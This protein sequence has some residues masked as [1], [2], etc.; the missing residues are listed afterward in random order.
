MI[1]PVVM[2][3]LGVILGLWGAY[4]IYLGRRP[5]KA[6]ASH[7]AF[8]VLYI[9]MA[10]FLILTT[11]GTIKPPRFGAPPRRPSAELPLYA[12]PRPPAAGPASQVGRPPSASAP[13]PAAPRTPASAP[14]QR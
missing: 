14:A 4:R 9:L 11:S 2:Y 6:R 7:L 10:G 1:P 3:V 5:V 12:L 8:G 13:T